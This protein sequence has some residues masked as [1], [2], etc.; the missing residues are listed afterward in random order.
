LHLKSQ[1]GR[2]SAVVKD[3]F[4]NDENP[5]SESPDSEKT[6]Y[7]EILEVNATLINGQRTNRLDLDQVF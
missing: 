2:L 5:G 1:P 6:P 3:I 7:E 4:E